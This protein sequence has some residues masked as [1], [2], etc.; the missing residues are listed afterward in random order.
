[1]TSMTTYATGCSENVL[2]RFPCRRTDFIFIDIP[3]PE[4][5]GNGNSPRPNR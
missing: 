3:E 5:I 1:M 2:L 4:K